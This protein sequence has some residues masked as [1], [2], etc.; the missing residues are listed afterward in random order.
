MRF[1]RWKS[2]R[3]LNTTITLYY[4]RFFLLIPALVIVS[5]CLTRGVILLFTGGTGELNIEASVIARSDFRLINIRGVQKAGGWVEILKDGKVIYVLGSKLDDVMQYPDDMAGM[6]LSG[7]TGRFNSDFTDSNYFYSVASF[8]GNDSNTYTCLVKIPLKNPD[9]TP[10]RAI[11]TSNMTFRLEK[12]IL[13]NF[14]VM[15]LIFCLLFILCIV[16]YGRITAKKIARP[17]EAIGRGLESV[18]AGDLSTRMDFQAEKEFAD[19]RDAFNYMAGRLQSA[20]AEKSEMEENRKKMI[21]GISHDLKTPITT[22]YGYAKA[23]SDGMV[24]DPEKRKRHLAY[25][26]DKALAMSKLIDDLFRYSTMEGSE[27][28]L[29]RKTEDF[30]E[31]LREL[32][33]ENY[34]EIENRGFSLDLD[35]PESPVL[36]P[37]DRSE[38]HR[39]LSNIL[40][41][42]LKYNPAGTTLSVK[43]AQTEGMLRLSIGDDGV[44]ISEE[45]RG[46]VFEEFV[47]GDAAR[48]SDGGSGLGLAIAKRIVEMHGGSIELTSAP[49]KGSVFMVTLPVNG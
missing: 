1:H 31:F 28:T 4:L 40:G 8:E 32:I 14:A 22:V 39:A 30:G 49:G 6:D 35:I 24:E 47:R 36:C 19:I 46:A 20:E 5:M 2:H 27:Y 25:I 43:L 41:N 21:M 29:N 10:N 13:L 42:S 9:G 12:V 44:G 18:T 7:K 45:I 38:M 26:R 23:L 15:V 33:A 37:F 11:D 17:L 48:P 3:N 34:L 16:V